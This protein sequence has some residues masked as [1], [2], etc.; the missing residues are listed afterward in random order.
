MARVLAYNA[1]D[2]GFHPQHCKKCV[3]GG[4]FPRAFQ[5]GGKK[6]FPSLEI[7]IKELLKCLKLKTN[8]VLFF[9]N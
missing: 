5:Y 4:E 2:P 1:E 3:S 6:V 7:S 9:F 8:H